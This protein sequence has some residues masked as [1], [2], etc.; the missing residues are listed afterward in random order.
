[1]Q[2]LQI[3]LKEELQKDEYEN[4]IPAYLLQNNGSNSNDSNE[5]LEADTDRLKS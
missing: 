3:E 4:I 5:V 2:S 1:M